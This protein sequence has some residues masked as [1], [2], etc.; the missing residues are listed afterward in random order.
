MAGGSKTVIFA[1]LAGNAAIAV[2]KFAASAITGSAAMLSEAVHS[3]VDTGNQLL[4]LL[5]LHQSKRPPDEHHP[6]GYG[7]RLYFWSFIVAIVIFGFGGGLSIWEGIEKIREPHQIES[8]WLNYV[9]LAL[10]LAIEGT[11]WTVA[12]REFR[13]TKGDLGWIQAVRESKDPLVFTVLFEDA[14]AVLGLAVAFVGIYLS[15]A[16][17]LPVLDGVASVLIGLILVCTAG[18]LAREC[19]A[20]L[21]G[22]G[23]KPQLRKDI[24]E[25][26]TGTPGVQGV[27]ELLTMHFGPSD[28]LV[29]ISLDFDDRI[30]AA[31]VESAVSAMESAIKRKHP[32]IQRIFVE[33]QDPVHHV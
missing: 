25:I 9:V 24:K 2:A 12:L 21:T 19:Q 26:I 16:L 18:F 3:T 8:A 13:K 31:D 20:L 23:V 4:L 33:A 29:A 6:F 11:V 15:Q 32:E 17:D 7:L 28:V 1:A 27:N 10:S 14:A 30:S 22:E 5:G